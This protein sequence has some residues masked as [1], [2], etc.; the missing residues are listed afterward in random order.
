MNWKQKVDTTQ[1]SIEKNGFL[2]IVSHEDSKSKS[3][4]V[5]DH[6]SPQW[7]EEWGVLHDAQRWTCVGWRLR[8]CWSEVVCFGVGWSGHEECNCECQR[9]QSASSQWRAVQCAPKSVFSCVLN[10]CLGVGVLWQEMT[11]I[12]D[13]FIWW[14]EGDGIHQSQKPST[15]TQSKD[16]CHS[17]HPCTHKTQSTCVS[18]GVGDFHCDLMKDFEWLTQPLNGLLSKG[19]DVFT[20][21]VKRHNPTCLLLYYSS[22]LLCG[23]WTPKSSMKRGVG[24]VAWC[25]KVNMCW[26]KVEGVLKWGG[27][28][29]SWMKWSW[30]V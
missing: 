15:Q 25:T 11:S 4:R 12:M 9:H 23:F 1:I 20:M 2:R 18:V 19:D 13:H 24:S 16:D 5:T 21:G 8:E 10:E 6:Q 27:V 29:W 30:R 14:E 26:V 7:K 22:F 3:G 28:F 17:P